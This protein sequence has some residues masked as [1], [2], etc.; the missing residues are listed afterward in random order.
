MRRSR[1]EMYV[2]ILNVLALRGP[3]KLTHIMYKANVNCSILK[4]YIHF[5]IEQGLVEKRSL[6][7]RRVEY[8][9]SNKGLSV[10]KQ[11]KELK[12]I[13]PLIEEEQKAPPFF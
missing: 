5:L 10:L 12:Q 3:V 1:L 4:E 11:F 8:A 2:D 7:K 6:G 9:I 13:L